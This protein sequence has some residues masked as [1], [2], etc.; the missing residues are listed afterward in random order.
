MKL[1]KTR[2]PEIRFPLPAGPPPECFAGRTSREV[3]GEIIAKLS[4]NTQTPLVS[5]GFSPETTPVFPRNRPV[6]GGAEKQTVSAIN[7]RTLA[8]SH[9]VAQKLNL[10]MHIY[11]DNAVVSSSGLDASQNPYLT[12]DRVRN[13][14]RPNKFIQANFYETL[15]PR[16]SF[17]HLFLILFLISFM[18]YS[19]VLGLRLSYSMLSAEN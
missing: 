6:R 12:V 17:G 16:K 9:G 1:G 11:P 3:T 4:T 2:R 18:T 8:S 13:C 14:G 19:N 10:V 5:A 15:N 7:R